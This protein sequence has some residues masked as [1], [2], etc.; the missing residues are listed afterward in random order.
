MS[1]PTRTFSK[2]EREIMNC[3][4]LTK[5][6]IFK[7]EWNSSQVLFRL[8]SNNIPIIADTRMVVLSKENLS[9]ITFKKNMARVKK[10]K[11]RL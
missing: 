11:P 6:L 7:A 1:N 5:G 10:P 4:I 2:V 3:L 9:P 8:N